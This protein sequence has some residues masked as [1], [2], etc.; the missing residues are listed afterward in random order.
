MPKMIIWLQRLALV[1]YFISVVCA[2]L[3]VITGVGLI[4]MAEKNQVAS[5]LGM[6]FYSLFVVTLVTAFAG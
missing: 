5:D 3:S 2:V 4:W 6:A 1:F